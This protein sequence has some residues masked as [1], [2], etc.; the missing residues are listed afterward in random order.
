[1]LWILGATALILGGGYLAYATGV[2]DEIY[3][4]IMNFGANLFVYVLAKVMDLF[5]WFLDLMPAL[6]YAG[7]YVNG[8]TTLVTLLARANTFFP[9]VETCLMFGFAV[10]FLLIFITVKFVLK[11][12]PT[13][14]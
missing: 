6:P 7:E 3:R 14:G 10:S 5:V 2:D 13:I 11:L 9:V 8:I 4:T 12:I 1:M